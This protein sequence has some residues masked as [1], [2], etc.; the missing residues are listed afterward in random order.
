MCAHISI[1]IIY[2]YKEEI[3]MENLPETLYVDP[4][5]VSASTGAESAAV[6]R[7][8]IEQCIQLLHQPSG[9]EEALA[10]L[11]KVYI[12]ISISICVNAYMSYMYIV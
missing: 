6:E 1:Y 2:T 8:K 12:S 5:A 11:N 4:T 10:L 7:A 9:R 3:K